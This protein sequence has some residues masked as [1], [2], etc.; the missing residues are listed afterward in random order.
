MKIQFLAC[1]R[2]Q[3]HAGNAMKYLGFVMRIEGVDFPEALRLL[4]KKAGV[5]LARRNPA[6]NSQKTKLM[7][8]L[9]SAAGFY[10]GEL[11]KSPVA[12][13]YI[14]KRQLNSETVKKFRLGF[15]P[16]SWD[17]LLKFFH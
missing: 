1:S 7:D 17:S 13:E 12:L 8:I 15:A 9:E 10:S 11:I 6:E 16:Q 3:N 5:E 14:G 4:A 2:P